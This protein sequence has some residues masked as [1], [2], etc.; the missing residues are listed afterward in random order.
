LTTGDFLTGSEMRATAAVVGASV[1][2][3]ASAVGKKMST[4]AR[5]LALAPGDV[6]SCVSFTCVDTS[7]R[8]VNQYKTDS[9]TRDITV[10]VPVVRMV[11]VVVRL[12]RPR[13][14][15]SQDTDYATEQAP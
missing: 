10:A 14:V 8:R 3:L 7:A 4:V 12:A 6:S 5:S 15:G 9:S 1:A 13:P 11:I 2:V